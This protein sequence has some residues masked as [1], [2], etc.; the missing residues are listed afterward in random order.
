MTATTF[1]GRPVVLRGPRLR[2]GDPAPDCTVLAD[3]FTPVRLLSAATG[4]RIIS[5]VP[6]LDTDV[7]DQQTRRFHEEATRLTGVSVLTVSVDLPFAQRR[8]CATS[9]LDGVRTLSDHRELAFGQ[10]YGVAVAELRVLARAVFVLGPDDV[11]RYAQY[12]G[13]IGEHPGYDE[14]LAAVSRI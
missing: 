8:W 9:G 7:C 10:A 14:V 13:E 4:I 1:R 5:S 3:D 11:I 2:A 6:S 12:V